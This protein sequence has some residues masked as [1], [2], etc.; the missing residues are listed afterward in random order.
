VK[1]DLFAD[2]VYVFTPEG[3]IH[4]FPKGATPIDFAFAIHTDVGVHCLGRAG[5]R[6]PRAAALPAAP[7]RHARDPDQPEPVRAQGVAQDVPDL[8][9]ARADQGQC[10]ASR[11]ACRVRSLGRSLIEQELAGRGR[12]LAEFEELGLVAQAGRGV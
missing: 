3:D 12:T 4:T 2:E 7:G 6:P 10:C 5:Q 8:A 9:G 1:A 11:S